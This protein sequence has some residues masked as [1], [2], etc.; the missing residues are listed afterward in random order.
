M[1]RGGGGD[2]NQVVYVDGDV[3][4]RPLQLGQLLVDSS[5]I[6]SGVTNLQQCTSQDPLVYGPIQGGYPITPA[7]VA[8]GVTI[9]IDRYAPGVFE[10]YGAIGDDATNDYAAINDALLQSGQSGGTR[11]RAGKDSTYF[12]GANTLAIPQN[13]SVD[14]SGAGI[15]ST[16]PGVFTFGP[17]G[18]LFGY[19]AFIMG[20]GAAGAVL[21]LTTPAV[22]GYFGIF[23]WPLVI[24]SSTAAAGSIG[25]DF[26]GGIKGVF[27]VQIAENF[28]KG[29]TGGSAATT[30]QTYY[31]EFRSPKVRCAA[32]GVGM[33]FRNGCNSTVVLNPQISGGLVGSTG[34]AV[35]QASSLTI[36]GGYVEAM[37]ASD[38]T[39]GL[40]I[41]DAQNIS[42]YGTTFDQDAL[43]V[44]AS[45]A[46]EIL[47]AATQINLHGCGFGGGWGASS[48]ILSKSGAGLFNFIGPA[49][50]NH[51]CIIGASTWAGSYSNGFTSVG[52]LSGLA[53]TAEASAA[54][55]YAHRLL[56]TADGQG[57]LIENNSANKTTG[58]SVLTLNRVGGPG[59]A[60]DFQD[61]GSQR[62][63][64]VFCT[65]TPEAQI[66]AVVGTL[67]LRTDGGAGSTLYIK[68]TGAGN[69][70]W[71]AK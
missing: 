17:G 41:T 38:T 9:V 20:S 63:G 12:I 66:T 46:I 45:K 31:N 11:A 4:Q 65:G 24:A 5:L 48:R 21:Q 2:S 61:N 56:N 14:I 35:N 16:N 29:I 54:A 18:E 60:I 70:G 69:T 26:T 30:P 8:A 47:G 43:D 49:P 44:T 67:A 51:V 62:G 32:A 40:L 39:R 13:G 59:Y 34:F 28:L 27:E 7:E 42:V 36:L 64:I 19:G 58:R 33:E 52:N 1:G 25:L 50:T 68:E 57:A 15:R 3:P 37:V 23:G 53:I 71:V 6:S 10:R 55:D 22:P